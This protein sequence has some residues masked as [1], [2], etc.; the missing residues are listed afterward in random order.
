MRWWGPHGLTLSVCEMDVRPGGAW[1]FVLRQP[2]GRDH[3]FRGVYS[4]VIPPERIVS[5]FIYDVDFIRDF[6]AI[7][8]VN[9]DECD[10]VTTLRVVAVHPTRESRDGH[11]NSGMEGGASQ[12]YDR[13]AELLATLA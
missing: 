10:G 5:T 7:E 8:T 11:L 12:S 6:P 2:D 9:F 4:E 1:R 3:P 13:L